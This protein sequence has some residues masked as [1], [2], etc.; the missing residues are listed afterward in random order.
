MDTL[1]LGINNY[2]IN[3]MCSSVRT[4]DMCHPFALGVVAKQNPNQKGDGT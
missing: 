4:K 2:V 3:G 1:K